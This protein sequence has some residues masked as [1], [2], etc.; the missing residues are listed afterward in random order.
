[1]ATVHNTAI[2]DRK[3]QLGDDVV[4][5]PYAIITGPVVV[6]SGSTIGPH[7]ILE[8]RTNIGR[9]CRIF[10][11]AVIGTI[12]QDLKFAGEDTYVEIGDGT[13]VREFVTINRGT[14]ASGKTTIGKKCLLMAYAHVAHDCHVGDGVV[15]ANNGT[16]GGHIEVGSYATIGGLSAIHQFVRIGAHAF[17][18][19]MSRIPQDILPYSLVASDEGTRVVGIN[20]L[21]LQRKGFKEDVIKDLRR[22]FHLLYRENLNTTQALERIEAELGGREEVR[23]IVEFVKT[24]ER[25]ILK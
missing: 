12:P 11:H 2:V 16:L 15:I 6:E 22:A 5:E 20:V 7:A 24:S 18:G 21:G 9:N 19:G 25:G 1:M 23:E 14:K 4:V 3:A 10:S 8:G 13:T 17:L